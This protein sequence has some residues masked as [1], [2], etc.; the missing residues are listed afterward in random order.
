MRE[1][2]ARIVWIARTQIKIVYTN[3]NKCLLEW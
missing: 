2:V 3:R 1:T